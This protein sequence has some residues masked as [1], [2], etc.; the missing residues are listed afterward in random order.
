MFTYSNTLFVSALLLPLVL[1]ASHVSIPMPQMSI[2]LVTDNGQGA[3]GPT[4]STTLVRPTIGTLTDTS[5]DGTMPFGYVLAGSSQATASVSYGVVRIFAAAANDIGAQATATASAGF[6][7]QVLFSHPLLNGQ[8]GLAVGYWYVHG[9]HL[10]TTSSPSQSSLVNMGTSLTTTDLE[11]VSTSSYDARHLVSA[12]GF[13]EGSS[14]FRLHRAEVPFI[15]G[16]PFIFNLSI[17]VGVAASDLSA[18]TGYAL[19]VA[20]LSNTALWQ[21]MQAID[22]ITGTPVSGFS[23]SSASGTNWLVGVPEPSTTG[24]LGLGLVA[25]GWLRRRR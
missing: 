7:D 19:A 2:Y 1:P 22:P 20:D 14:I 24:L 10:T 13:T 6:A 21:G 5:V 17:G 15:W 9:S 3:P 12:S 23:F 16:Q 8:S 4:I 25:F 11:G 18:R